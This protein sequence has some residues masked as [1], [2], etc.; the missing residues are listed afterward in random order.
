MHESARAHTR[1]QQGD[2]KQM[3]NVDKLRDAFILHPFAAAVMQ[4][5]LTLELAL[6][7]LPMYLLSQCL[8]RMFSLPPEKAR[9]YPRRIQKCG[10]VMGGGAERERSRL[11]Q[12]HPRLTD[13]WFLCLVA[14]TQVRAAF[15]GDVFFLCRGAPF[16]LSVLKRLRSTKIHDPRLSIM[17]T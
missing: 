4:I 13:R 11:G 7:L 6:V 5:L 1:Y 17:S 10:E 16:S 3:G 9:E 15:R 12:I 2:S 8:I 14:P